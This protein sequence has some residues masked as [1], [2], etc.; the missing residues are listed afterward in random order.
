MTRIELQAIFDKNEVP[1][2]RYSFRGAGG[3]DVWAL[4]RVGDTFELCYYN[5]KGTREDVVSYDNE[6][7]GC[8]AFLAKISDMLRGLQHRDI[9]VD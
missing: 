3:G 4:E 9:V 2:S 8:L 1:T 7:D 5:D 6:N